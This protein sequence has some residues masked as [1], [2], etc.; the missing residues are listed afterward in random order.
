MRITGITGTNC[1]GKGLATTILKE[2]GF[3]AYN[4][5]E[6]LLA[7]AVAMGVDLADRT[8]IGAFGTRLRKEHGPAYLVERLLER[9]ICENKDLVVI[10]SIRHPAEIDFLEA[11]C[12]QFLLL[13]VDAYPWFRY[14]RALARGQITDKVSFEG[15]L[16]EE[17]AEWNSNDPG[18]MSIRICM[19]R[20]EPVLLNNGAVS[21]FRSRVIR[22]GH[23][24]RPI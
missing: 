7:E 15:F 10:E 23:S 8:A 18:G 14:W 17:R 22:A 1:A 5:R 19:E 24:L 6:F 4:V 9:A 16:A 20:A 2:M 21:E 13:G 12:E 11:H 3:S